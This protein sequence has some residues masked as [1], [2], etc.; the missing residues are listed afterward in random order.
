MHTYI[1]FTIVIG[2]ADRFLPWHHAEAMLSTL[3]KSTLD[4]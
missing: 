2:I 3:P 4:D 1:W